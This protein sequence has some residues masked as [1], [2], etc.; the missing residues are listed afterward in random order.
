MPHIYCLLADDKAKVPVGEPDLPTSTDVGG[1]RSIAPTNI[2]R[3]ALD[4]DVLQKD[5]IKPIINQILE[6]EG[7][8]SIAGMLL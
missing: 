1:E 4:H 6:V 8:T 2:N 5:T 7:T 3:S